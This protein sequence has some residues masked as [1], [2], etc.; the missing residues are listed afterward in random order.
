[1]VNDTTAGRFCSF[2]LTVRIVV[3]CI[4]R[5]LLPNVP[6]LHIVQLFYKKKG[7]DYYTLLI[8]DPLAQNIIG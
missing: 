4:M 8:Q 6:Q 2:R 5:Y 7:V 1:M 3:T